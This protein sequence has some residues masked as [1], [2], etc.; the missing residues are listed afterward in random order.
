L[1]KYEWLRFD[2]EL[3]KMFC[4]HCKSLDTVG[5]FITGCSSFKIESVETHSQ[6]AGHRKN[7]SVVKAKTQNVVN[8]PAM[9]CLRMM[10]A[11]KLD[12]LKALFR[13]APD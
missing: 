10:N 8:S 13:K 7:V 6:S 1:K 2:E 3:Q 9:G 12:K 4:V 5:T 11:A